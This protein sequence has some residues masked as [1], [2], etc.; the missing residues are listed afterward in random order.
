MIADNN[1]K[2]F[3]NSL[4]LG[5][6]RF[7]ETTKLSSQGQVIIPKSLREAHHWEADQELLVIDVGDGILLKPKK[8]F[9]ETKLNEVAGCL[10]Y[11]GTPKSLE[12]MDEAICQGIEELWHDRG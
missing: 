3:A 9:L 6:D 2:I 5:L 8:P 12:D 4:L 11:H 1:A 10:E 7:M